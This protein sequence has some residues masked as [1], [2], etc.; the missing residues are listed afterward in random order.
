MVKESM[1]GITKYTLERIDSVVQG[2]P[3]SI[4][5]KTFGEMMRLPKT[6][7]TVPPNYKQDEV[8]EMCIKLALKYV[9]MHKE[10]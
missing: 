4:I 5:E 7:I 10:G 2:Q 8:V 3:I 1:Q 6:K 9:I